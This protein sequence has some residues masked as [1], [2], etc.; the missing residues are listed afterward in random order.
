ML[1][2]HTFNIR[3]IYSSNESSETSSGFRARKLESR[4]PM[5]EE[6]MSSVLKNLRIVYVERETERKRVLVLFGV[7]LLL[8]CCVFFCFSFSFFFFWFLRLFNS[9]IEMCWNGLKIISEI[10][11]AAYFVR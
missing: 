8:G 7:L 9:K 3:N 5:P 4:A 11:L 2:L 6:W 1:Y 10:Y